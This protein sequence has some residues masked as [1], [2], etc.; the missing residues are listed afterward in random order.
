MHLCIFHSFTSCT[1]IAIIPIGLLELREE[2]YLETRP[3]TTTGFQI[4][5]TSV[6][7]SLASK[8]QPLSDQRFAGSFCESASYSGRYG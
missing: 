8:K 6:R 4:G 1:F 2:S 3:P 5:E 7:S